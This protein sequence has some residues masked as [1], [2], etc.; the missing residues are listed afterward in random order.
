MVPAFFKIMLATI[1]VQT[2]LKKL[3]SYTGTLPPSLISVN[4]NALKKLE[5]NINK[6]PLSLF[7]IKSSPI[8][9]S[10]RNK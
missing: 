2:F 5:A 10:I 3:F 8:D 9:F 6:I 1:I 4:V 7:F